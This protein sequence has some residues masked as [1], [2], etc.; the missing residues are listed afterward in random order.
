MLYVLSLLTIAVV[1][2]FALRTSNSRE[3]RLVLS[4]TIPRPDGSVFAVIGAVERAPVWYR[5]PCW[6]PGPLRISIMTPWGELSPTG[7]RKTGSRPNGPEEIW[8]R[9]L[10]NREFGYRSIR[11][12][13]LSYESTFRLSQ[14][15]GK[16]RLTWE[17]RY[18]VHRLPDIISQAAI[19]TAARASM[20]NS[21]KL[22]Q[23][24]AL[25]SPDAVRARDL[26]YE[27]RR[28]QISAA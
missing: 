3:T 21:F 25:S 27:A 22:I 24:L 1:A 2:F 11:R 14:E 16:C 19:A 4:A 20:A 9:H 26:I 23:R 12:R 6:L 13:D 18:Q 5:Q 15:D 7:K 8:I 17:V 28:D 10:K